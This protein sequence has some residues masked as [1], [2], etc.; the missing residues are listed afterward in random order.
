MYSRHHLA[1]AGTLVA[2]GLLP[3]TGCGED[4]TSSFE[5]NGKQQISPS[6]A[7]ASV[8]VPNSMPSGDGPIEPGTYRIPNSAWSV[9]DFS[10]TFPQDWTVQYGH[11]YARN[12]DRDDEFGF[13]AVVV[14]EIFADGC[15]GSSSG[16]IEF[17]PSVDDLL[18]ALLEQPGPMK[19]GPVE[20]T[21]GGYPATRL[22]LTVPE[23]FD[24]GPCNV[25][26]IGLQLWYSVPADKNFVLLDDGSA[27][28][29]ILDVNG[30]RQV[31]LTQHGSTTSDEDLAELQEVLD[32]I[33]IE[34]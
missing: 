18:S 5:T 2:V 22:D 27:S 31:F 30:E 17:G 23:D 8:P 12:Q 1:V 21:L 15:A 3:I 34:S 14:D 13:Y 26:D 11:V 9:A 25:A 7:I 28:V 10:V 19:S 6:T 20:T 4:T 16:V 33:S 29:Y 32:S 24:L